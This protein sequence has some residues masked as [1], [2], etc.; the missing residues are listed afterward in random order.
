LPRPKKCRWVSGRPVTFLYKPQGV[1]LCELKGMVLPVEGLEALRLADAQGLDQGQAAE[2]MGISRPTF[3]RIL[4]E[5]RS[6]V[7]RSL[8]NGWA[9]RIEGGSYRVKPGLHPYQADLDGLDRE[10]K[11][12][13]LER[14][15]DE[16]VGAN[17]NKQGGEIMPN[18]D[19]TG[20]AGQGPRGKGRGPCG[21][22]RG[23]GQGRGQGK[24]PGLGKGGGKGQGQRSGPARD[25]QPGDK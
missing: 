2:L 22:G 23:A 16:D 5:A 19:K 3:C 8:V 15:A 6:I 10:D 9:I 20:P 21:Q 12:G 1:P 14:G 4:A 11:P 7:A 17:P 13:K 24:G 25:R 18:K